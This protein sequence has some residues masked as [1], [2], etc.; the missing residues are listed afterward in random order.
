MILQMNRRL[1]VAIFSALAIAA[2][3]VPAAQAATVGPATQITDFS[4]A[5]TEGGGAGKYHSDAVNP[6][7]GA[8]IAFYF[9]QDGSDN[10]LATQRFTADGPVGSENVVVT[11]GNYATGCY[12]NSIAYNPT[13]GG[14]FVAYPD[15]NGNQIIG[16]LLDADGSNSG[17]SFT[18]GS[19]DR[20]VCSGLKINWDSNSKKFLV[21]FASENADDVKARFVSGNGTALG[22]TFTALENVPNSYC[23]MDTAYSSK[24]NTFLTSVG[25]ECLATPAQGPLIQFLSGTG[26][27]VGSAR[28][29]GNTAGDYSYAPAIAYNAKLDEFGVIWQR[30]ISTSPVVQAEIYLQRIEASSGA[31][32]GGPVQIEPP[33]S[34]D[35]LVGA[36]NRIR[37]AVSP[38]GQYYI[39]A[40]LRPDAS[41]DYNDSSW[42]SFKFSGT[43]NT[44][45]DSLEDI[46]NGVIHPV[47]VQ[48]LYNPVTGQFLSTFVASAESGNDFNLYLNGGP[49]SPSGGKPTLKKVGTPGGTSLSV[50]V[51]CTGGGSCRVRLGGKLVGGSGKLQGK[52]VKIGSAGVTATGT[53]TGTTARAKASRTVTLA[54]TNALIRQ[55]AANGGG[56]IRVKAKQVGGGSKTI[57]VTVPASV[58]G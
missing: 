35:D 19:I 51:G 58:T 12:Q 2:F 25:G 31:N 48:N 24:S 49:G 52:T 15:N 7:T 43:G 14:W 23:P 37:V 9:G 20:P 22:S 16:Q 30:R 4:P 38:S 6:K 40:H 17:A 46:S 5:R 13:T 26:A 11:G 53:G 29:I 56:K 36:G 28:Y 3:A 34:S 32:V 18:V 42:Y 54:Y 1:A 21:T 55:L 27:T 33:T 10:Y 8:Q 45:A 57:T 41:T 47:R 50:R 39:S 44:V